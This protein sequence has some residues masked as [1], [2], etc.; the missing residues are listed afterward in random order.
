MT[1]F[2]LEKSTASNRTISKFNVID[3]DGALCGII[4][5]KPE[6]EAD[7]RAHWKDVLAPQAG[8]KQKATSNTGKQVAAMIKAGRKPSRESVLRGC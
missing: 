5:V 2:K 8:P 4:S 1:T 3:G 6:E 7:F